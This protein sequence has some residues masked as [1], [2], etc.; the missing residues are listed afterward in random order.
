M[1]S[2]EELYE[3]MDKRA[4]AIEKGLQAMG[5][6]FDWLTAHVLLLLGV[7]ALRQVGSPREQIRD[8]VEETMR[9]EPGVSRW[10]VHGRDKEGAS[11][12][13]EADGPEHLAAILET[14]RK[15]GGAYRLERIP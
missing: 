8:L 7:D 12:T 9:P 3:E 10:I 5:L 2:R 14:V 11:I 6:P 15:D 13:Y 4:D 1:T